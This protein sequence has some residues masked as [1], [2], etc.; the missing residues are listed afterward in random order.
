MFIK[1]LSDSEQEAL[2]AGRLPS[3]RKM[4]PSLRARLS[5]RSGLDVPV[6]PLLRLRPVLVED[7]RVYGEV[8]VPEVVD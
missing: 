8:L 7:V 3:A 6:P 5:A 2:T 1:N 4:G